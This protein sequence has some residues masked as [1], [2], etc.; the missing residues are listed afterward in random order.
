MVFNF[1]LIIIGACYFMGSIVMLDNLHSPKGRLARS[2][3]PRAYFE[4][5]SRMGRWAFVSLALFLLA[6]YR[7]FG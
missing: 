3:A 7:I 1:L 5:K 6:A 4:L 2:L